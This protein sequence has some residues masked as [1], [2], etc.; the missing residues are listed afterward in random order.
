MVKRILVL[1][2]EKLVSNLLKKRL[3]DEDYQ[4][5][6]SDD[7]E[8]ALVIIIR[9]KINLIVLDLDLSDLTAFSFLVK[10]KSDSDLKKIPV[11]VISNAGQIGELSQ[12]QELGATDWVL[13]TEF[14][15]GEI[16]QKVKNIFK[17]IKATS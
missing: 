4:V 13:K 17:S 5:V 14:D 11:L 3:S 9:E 12:A 10:K 2:E 6:I 16:A 1:T 7:P 8:K 15:P